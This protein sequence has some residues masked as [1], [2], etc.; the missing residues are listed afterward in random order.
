MN[1]EP[2]SD[3]PLYLIATKNGFSVHDNKKVRM[4]ESA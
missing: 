3:L 4:E 2:F 1:Y